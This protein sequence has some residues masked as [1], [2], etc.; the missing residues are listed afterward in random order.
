MS[1][2]APLV[3]AKAPVPGQV[4]TRLAAD[5]G[6]TAAADLAAAA[7]L[8]TLD[9]VLE[10]F[11][12][13][14]RVVALAGDLAAAERSE[15]IVEALRGWI[16]LPQRGES[17]AERIGWAH[18]DLHEATGRSSLQIGMDTPHLASKMLVDAAEALR[19]NDAVLGL[20]EDGGWWVLGLCDP[21]HARLLRDV[22]TSS[23][24]TGNL[25]LAALNRE[26]TIATAAATYDVDTV[27][28]ASRAAADAPGT[29][30]A[31]AWRALP[32]TFHDSVRETRGD[33]GEGG[34][35]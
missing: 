3:L 26:L 13:G 18:V 5:V 30:F 23:T 2:P 28:E 29:R 11:P 21:R 25:T 24:D 22:P 10:A 17:F 8:D 15:Q 33:S 4:K 32:D 12:D 6:A 1:A 27:V 19:T 34:P 7:L 14:P 9:V 16:V 20:A 35:R 31:T